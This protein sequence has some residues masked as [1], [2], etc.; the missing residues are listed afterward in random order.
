MLY[1]TLFDLVCLKLSL[2][3]LLLALKESFFQLTG[4]KLQLVVLF[5]LLFQVVGN[6]SQ[7]L[8]FFLETV[9]QLFHI[10]IGL[11]NLQLASQFV[12]SG[13]LRLSLFFIGPIFILDSPDFLLK[14]VNLNGHLFERTLHLANAQF[15]LVIDE[16]VLLL[17]LVGQVQLGL[18][19]KELPLVV[20]DGLLHLLLLLHQRAHLLLQKGHHQS[21][22]LGRRVLLGLRVLPL[23]L[24]LNDYMLQSHPI[25]LENSQIL[26]RLSLRG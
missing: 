4:L 14:G 12:D 10:L 25:F 16:L 22:L 26:S 23:L 18:E 13:L 6:F 15:V 2:F 8:I 3:S 19:A 7:L 1:E 9:F 5:H 11:R 20:I 21:G 17:L 24:F